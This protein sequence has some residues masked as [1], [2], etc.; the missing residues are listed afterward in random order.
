MIYELPKDISERILE[1]TGQNLSIQEALEQWE[2][3]H[4]TM[5]RLFDE[6]NAFKI[7][8]RQAYQA[9]LAAEKAV[10]AAN[11]DSA[12]FVTPRTR[13]YIEKFRDLHEKVIH[14]K[15]ATAEIIQG[16]DS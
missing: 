1:I 12:M 15:T 7:Y 11:N 8:L 5:L 2:Q 3:E 10:Q 9:L 4:S 16:V 14:S 13:A 6:N